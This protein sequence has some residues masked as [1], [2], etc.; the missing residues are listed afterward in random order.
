MSVFQGFGLFWIIY[1]LLTMLHCVRTLECLFCFH[2]IRNSVL[3]YITLMHLPFKHA[4]TRQNECL[5]Y[6]CAFTCLALRKINSTA[7]P[8][9]R[10]RSSLKVAYY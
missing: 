7:I 9:S 10:E 3:H 2:A 1:D 8:Y 6:K 4:N 5:G